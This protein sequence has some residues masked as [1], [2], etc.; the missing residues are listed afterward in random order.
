MVLNDGALASHLVGQGVWF[1][2]RSSTMPSII[3]NGCDKQNKCP[4]MVVRRICDN[5]S[6]IR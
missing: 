5:K 3:S 4:E 2:V 1:R 6:A